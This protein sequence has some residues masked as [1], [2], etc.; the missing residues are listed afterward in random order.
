MSATLSARCFTIRVK[1]ASFLRRRN[2]FY[3]LPNLN[4][5]NKCIQYLKEQYHP[6]AILL[7]GS[8][9]RG[10]IEASSDFDCLLIVDAKEK[11]HDDRVIDQVQLDCFIFT[12]EE[13]AT[14][15]PSTFLTAYDAELVWDDGLGAKLQNRVRAY[16]QDHK[17]LKASEKD[18]IIS[19][20]RKTLKRI[21]KADDEGHYRALMLLTDSLEDYF[22][23]RDMFYFGSKAA[24][25]EIKESDP[26]GYALLHEALVSRTNA[27]IEAWAAHVIKPENCCLFVTPKIKN[28]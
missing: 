13:T 11:D 26:E 7:Y 1:K 27:S 12:S 21:K 2:S 28:P 15:D 9:A 5:K 14:M 18:F 25:R 20:I 17:T 8:Y 6:R 10:D 22:R 16:V 19:W 3:V 24:I 23:L 4:L